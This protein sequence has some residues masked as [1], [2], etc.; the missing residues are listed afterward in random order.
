M[1]TVFEADRRTSLVIRNAR[2]EELDDVVRVLH[3]AYQEHIPSPLPEAHAQAWRAYWQDIGDVRGR[4]PCTELIVA[5]LA[6][7]IVGTVTFYPDGTRAEDAG[8][9]AGWAGIRLLGVVPEA[10]GQGIG[11]ALTEECLIRAR[12]HSA[13]VIG[14]HT[15]DW[16]RVARG[17]YE[18]MGFQ[19]APEYDFRPV[20]DLTVLAYRLPVD[21]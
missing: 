11:R 2:A 4:L 17:M 7:R 6:D 9:P 5:E 12:R 16:M 15:N 10:R 1:S 19:R 18:R 20:P 3:R 14:L 8:W 13:A 21:R